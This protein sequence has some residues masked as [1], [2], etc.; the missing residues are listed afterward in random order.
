M[1]EY[2]NAKCSICGKKYHVCADCANTKSFMPWKT[3]ACSIDCYKIFIALRDY[4]NGYSTKEDIK[5]ILE[6]CDL[7]ELGNYED[8]I[9]NS[10]M[11]ILKKPVTKKTRNIIKKTDEN[12]LND[13]IHIK[14]DCASVEE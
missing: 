8:N 1:A 13:T 5:P 11:E 3:I 14:D 7:S 10:I 2:L 4:T 9:K 6:K 12:K